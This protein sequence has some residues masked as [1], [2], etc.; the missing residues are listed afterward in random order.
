M[1]LEKIQKIGAVCAVSALVGCSATNPAREELSFAQP[2]RINNVVHY[3][4]SGGVVISSG[5]NTLDSY[6]KTVCVAPPAQAVQEAALKALTNISGSG[7]AAAQIPDG[8]SAQIAANLVANRAVEAAATVSKLFEQNERT[9]L[10]QYSLYRLCE[11]HMNGMFDPYESPA[12]DLLMLAKEKNV[13]SEAA[14]MA[15]NRLEALR[16]A[17]AR[18]DELTKKRIELLQNAVNEKFESKKN[19]DAS[20]RSMDEEIHQLKRLHYKSTYR[21][22][23]DK[24]LDTAVRLA[25]IEKN[26]VAHDASRSQS[27]SEVAA[28]VK[29]IVDQIL[30]AERRAIAAQG[31]AAAATKSFDHLKNKLIDSALSC[32]GCEHENENEILAR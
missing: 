12:I 27:E 17:Q 15:M 18:I 1:L 10:L 32:A 29:E 31:N 11:A 7:S 9:L 2:S 23:F 24:I 6:F 25:E 4:G 3:P 19:R 22:A 14:E 5:R 28:K 21:E 16:N 30:A 13:S 8:T 26:R 20:I